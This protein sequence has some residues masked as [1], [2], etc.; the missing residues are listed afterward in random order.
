MF[1]SPS[2]FGSFNRATMLWLHFAFFAQFLSN[3]LQLLKFIRTRTFA[4]FF[5]SSS[6]FCFLLNS[7]MYFAG[8]WHA[9]RAKDCNMWIKSLT[10]VAHSTHRHCRTSEWTICSLFTAIFF[11]LMSFALL[12]P[13][14]SNRFAVLFYF[15][16]CALFPSD[17]P[18]VVHRFRIGQNTTCHTC[19]VRTTNDDR[20]H[21][22][23]C[24]FSW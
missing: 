17:H 19:N 1:F 9:R 6:F 13:H 10:T 18:D 12:S 11:L 20:A 5:L 22:L 15:I 16:F 4:L 2:C 14:F 24:L 7:N 8:R 23:V 3:N 21:S